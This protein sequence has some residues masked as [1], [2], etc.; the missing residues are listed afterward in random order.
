MNIFLNKTN[1]PL[2]HIFPIFLLYACLSQTQWY[3]V[4]PYK[5]YHF[6]MLCHP[7]TTAVTTILTP[8]LPPPHH[9]TNDLSHFDHCSSW[10]LLPPK[11]CPPLNQ[12]SILYHILATWLSQ[13]H[14]WTRI[15][16]LLG[17]C[18]NK[19]NTHYCITA[20]IWISFF[21][22]YINI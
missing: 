12:L 11:T 2:S 4:I 10:P 19:S 15:L 5:H 17:Q 21:D 13:A 20:V 18:P 16:S 1:N 6:P 3:F 14:W 9:H 22:C 7:L 8:C